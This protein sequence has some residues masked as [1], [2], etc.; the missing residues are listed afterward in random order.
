MFVSSQ[1]GYGSLKEGFPNF[2][3]NKGRRVPGV[4]RTVQPHPLFL[5]EGRLPCLLP[6]PG[7][8][9]QVIGQVFEVNEAEFALMDELER[10][11]ESG[12][13]ERTV[14]SVEA[15]QDS[16]QGESQVFVYT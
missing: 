3:Y 9:L 7:R 4:F 1:D 15:L 2:H 12:G 8:G 13:Y 11:G 6:Q 5:A 14:I 16:S 10:V